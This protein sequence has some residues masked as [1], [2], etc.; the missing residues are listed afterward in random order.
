[1]KFCTRAALILYGI[2]MVD[3]N[4]SHYIIQ[5]AWIGFGGW[6]RFHISVLYRWLMCCIGG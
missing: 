5:T 1:M 4:E 6:V 3:P 2:C